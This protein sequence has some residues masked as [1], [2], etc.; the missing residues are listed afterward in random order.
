M[1]LDKN[2]TKRMKEH[3]ITEIEKGVFSIEDFG[4]D[5]VFLV[6]GEQRALLI[7]CG[8]GTFS[9]KN[10]VETLTKLPYD[11]VITHG[12]VD[13]VG[14]A[15]E[16]S[17][18]HLSEKDAELLKETDVKERRK[19]N[20]KMK[21]F[22][23]Q[24]VNRK[25]IT[26]Y[27]AVPEVKYIKEGDLFDLGGRTVRVIETPGHTK[28]SLSFLIENEGILFSGD[29]INPLY[30]MFI[31][32]T[33]T[34]EDVQETYEKLLDFDIKRIY[35]TH[36]TYAVTRDDLMTA[37]DGVHEILKKKNGR[38]RLKLYNYKTETFLY[39]DSKIH[40]K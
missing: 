35:P 33:A 36:L 1:A 23:M 20:F 28:G 6:T 38:G 15:G 2:L 10:A 22:G 37:L 14:G 25:A 7:D 32:D 34:F 30:M 31:G 27:G 12:H 9:L 39:R 5:K 29:I 4:L 40:K 24:G 11:V 18:I 16:F 8:T 17:M 26:G 13:H 19:Y 3:Q 21:L